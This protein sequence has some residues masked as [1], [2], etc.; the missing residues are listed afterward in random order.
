MQSHWKQNGLNRSSVPEKSMI[1]FV[2]CECNA[3]QPQLKTN[4]YRH[5]SAGQ[6]ISLYRNAI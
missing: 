6:V 1:L 4:A 2:V 5:V 3:Q